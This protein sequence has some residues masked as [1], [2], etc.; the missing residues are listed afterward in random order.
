MFDKEE[1]AGQRSLTFRFN[2]QATDRT[3]TKEEVD[4]VWQ[5]VAQA[6]KDLGA[7]VR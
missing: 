2:I 3:L 7:T 4:T 6:I 1:W 5:K